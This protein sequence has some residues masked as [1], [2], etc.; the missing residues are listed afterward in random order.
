MILGFGVVLQIGLLAFRS[1]SVPNR[2]D[3]SLPQRQPLPSLTVP[4]QKPP[5][6]SA[7]R[8]ERDISPLP[9]TSPPISLPSVRLAFPGNGARYQAPA[10]IA[11]EAELENPDGPVRV[12]FY[13]GP[14]K[15]GEADA[16]PYRCTWKGIRF[17]GHY[18]LTAKAVGSRGNDMESSK[19]W[20]TI[21]REPPAIETGCAG[22]LPASVSALPFQRPEIVQPR[23]GSTF[24]APA[25]IAISATAS[26]DAERVEFFEGK[27]R[28]GESTRPPFSFVWSSVPAGS[29]RLTARATRRESET[30]MSE[31]VS[32]V[33]RGPLAAPKDPPPQPEVDPRQ[34]DDAIRK[35]VA[36]LKAAGVKE[37]MA[38]G[39][40]PGL[41]ETPELIL[42]TLVHS[43]TSDADP[44][45]LKLLNVV[46]AKKLE[47]TYNV[48]LQAMILEELNRVKFQNRIAQCG[49]FLV[50]AQCANGQWSYAGPAQMGVPTTAARSDVASLG[51]V[52][53]ADSITGA[54]VKPKVTRTITIQRTQEGPAT[55]DNSN[56][57]YAALGL[58]ACHDAGILIP[59]IVLHRGRRWW[60]EAQHA[61]ESPAGGPRPEVATG[62][63]GGAMPAGWCY[64]GRDHTHRAYPSMTAGALGSL[65]I[66]GHLLDEKS[67]E[68][69]PTF[70]KGLAWLGRHF[71][72][73]MNAGPAEWNIDAPG[74]MQYYYL[75]AL[76]RAGVLC[77]TETF[78]AHRWYAEGAAAIL[79][80]QKPDGSWISPVPHGDRSLTTNSVWDTCFAVLFLRRATRPLEDVA[81]T[82]ERAR[83]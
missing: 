46:I 24:T 34:V 8:I 9:A 74:W 26:E 6:D 23:E 10:D 40:V 19:F 77:G 29:Y 57:Q 35:G 15:I 81:S 38:P 43:G 36:F 58:R 33:V 17:P 59:K 80:A 82:D 31:V 62:N 56:S 25:S 5:P 55:G 68:R 65:A 32:I 22:V 39:V 67:W 51:K 53:A 4:C 47:R 21:D 18:E 79:G 66:Y 13:H 11:M 48:A 3:A 41:G 52:F 45:V 63:G 50:D 20:V 60:R 7:E 44:D 28:L 1:E 64:G 2:T 54:R 73:T 42:W 76:E 75:Y 37:S 72:V 71:T 83:R 61:E 14:I 49:Q 12:E 69:D 70:Q 78:G 16:A 27:N 30:S